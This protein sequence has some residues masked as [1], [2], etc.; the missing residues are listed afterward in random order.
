MNR[1][2]LL[3]ILLVCCFVYVTPTLALAA[4]PAPAAPAASTTPAAPVVKV[5]T[6]GCWCTSKNGATKLP[7]AL[8]QDACAT[9]CKKAGERVAACAFTVNQLPERSSYCFTKTICA[10]QNGILDTKQA[11]DCISGQ[12]YCFPDPAKAEKVKLNVAIPN[13]VNPAS[14]L[15]LTGDIGEYINALFRFI[16]NAGMVLAIV[17]VMV[18][19]LQY[20]LGASSKDGVSKGKERMTN[21]VTGLVLLLCVNLIAST[22]NPYLIQLKV[23]KFPMVKRVDLVTATSCE[24]METEYIIK[25]IDGT[26]ITAAQKKC[27]TSGTIVS[28]KDGGSVAGATTCDYKKCPTAA[29]GCLGTGADAKCLACI[30]VMPGLPNIK[31]SEELCSQLS[32]GTTTTKIDGKDLSTTN[33]CSYTHDTDAL[34]V[35]PAWTVTKNAFLTTTPVGWGLT[36]LTAALSS[37]GTAQ[38]EDID[39]IVAGACGSVTIDCKKIKECKDYD[40]TPQFQTGFTSTNLEKMQEGMVSGKITIQSVCLENPCSTL[41]GGLVETDCK[42]D[43]TAKIMSDCIDSGPL[44]S[45]TCDP[46][47][48]SKKPGY[49]CV[50]YGKH[51]VCTSCKEIFKDNELLGKDVPLLPSSAVCGQ[52]KDKISGSTCAFTTDSD[53][54]GPTCALL[55][56]DCKKVKS[57]TFKSN[58]CD[59][60]DDFDVESGEDSDT[61]D[62]F[63]SG[64]ITLEKVCKDDP[65]G[66]AAIEGKAACEFDADTAGEDSCD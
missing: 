12:S 28:K 56:I 27:G 63:S 10:K 66:A 64:E 36:A 1:L 21:G 6:A 11:T 24:T 50:T 42:Y 47:T 4:E 48:C 58:A 5:C 44:K 38:A 59:A 49:G 9:A 8:G 14:P 41:K 30:A 61:L 33:H 26:E 45:K 60:Y 53:A 51:S 15:T 55:T 17:M 62:N 32:L 7:S 52:L 54:D 29:E 39:R 19:G 35:S 34:F 22:V 37:S 40:T 65:C 25:A 20:T 2:K 57:V 18:G 13:P 31:P 16:I 46:V 23:P 43:D 3:L